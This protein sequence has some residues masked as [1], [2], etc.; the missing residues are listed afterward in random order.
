MIFTIK[1]DFYIIKMVIIM[2]LNLIIL[3]FFIM[4]LGGILLKEISEMISFKKNG[5]IVKAK[6]LSIDRKDI[7][8]EDNSI[9]SINTKIMC[10]FEFNG[11]H[12]L[13]LEQNVNDKNTFNIEKLNVGDVID[14]IYD[15]SRDVLST[16]RF[17]KKSIFR[18]ILFFIIL[19][20][21]IIIALNYYYE[22]IIFISYNL[23]NVIIIIIALIFIMF[24][25]YKTI[26]LYVENKKMLKHSYIKLVGKVVDY[27]REVGSSDVTDSFYYPEI[28]Y[29]YE[30][31]NK[32]FISKKKSQKKKY[33]IGDEFPVLYDPETDQVFEKN[34]P[35]VW[36][37]ITIV[38][39]CAIIFFFFKK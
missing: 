24:P 33:R 17:I 3:L 28:E 39:A 16:K 32:T 6:V 4:I 10:E 30:G 23:S 36:L 19:M 35:L 31:K 38:I 27:Y 5:I 14:C 13:E 11:K 15:Q 18:I 26:S 2:D 9:K 8:N 12:T 25:L 22:N 7:R 29:S 1:M 21:L 20:V 37:I 34:N